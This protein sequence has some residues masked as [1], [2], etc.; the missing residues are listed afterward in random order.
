MVESSIFS[1]VNNRFEEVVLS[2]VSLSSWLPSLWIW[3]VWGR[4]HALH[5]WYHERVL[6]VLGCILRLLRIWIKSWQEMGKKPE[7]GLVKSMWYFAYTLQPGGWHPLL[8]PSRMGSRLLQTA[9]LTPPLLQSCWGR[10]LWWQLRSRHRN[11][12]KSIASVSVCLKWAFTQHWKHKRS[13]W[14]RCWDLGNAVEH[15]APGGS[16][17][18]WPPFRKLRPGCLIPVFCPS[19]SW[20]LCHLHFYFFV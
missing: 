13:C 3:P 10:D 14:F 12:G 8:P 19:D 11:Q 6:Y 16:S 2:C 18:V 1:S 4:A 5:N 9:P 17:L 7:D 20:Q 15:T